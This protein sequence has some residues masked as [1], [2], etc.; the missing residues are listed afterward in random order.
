M[1]MHNN[2]D[3]YIK[4]NNIN[5]IDDKYLIKRPRTLHVVVVVVV[6]VVVTRSDQPKSPAVAIVRQNGLSSASCR[7]S[8]A[9]TPVSRQI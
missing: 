8:V 4:Y 7:A 5:I 3:N 6:V 1:N 2:S 9:V